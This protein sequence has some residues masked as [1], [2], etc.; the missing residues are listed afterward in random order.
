[1]TRKITFLLASVL[2]L[3]SAKPGLAGPPGREGPATTKKATTTRYIRLLQDD[4]KEPL[5]LQTATVRFTSAAGAGGVTV[6]LVGV[7]HIGDR[8]YYRK[9]N[10]QLEQYDVVLFELVA[11]PNT[12]I[13]RGG[14]RD[15]N[16]PLA[17]VQTAMKAVLGLESQTERID[18]TRKN[19]V[20]ADLSFEQ[21]AEAI[22]KRGDTGLTLTL[23]IAADLLRQQNLEDM[24][25]RDAQRGAQAEPEIDLLG[26]LLDPD[27][28]V[29][30]KRILAEQLAGAASGDSGLGP[31]INTILISDR[32]AAAIG[33]LQKELAKG[34][35][36]I[37][38]FYGAAHMP[39]FERRLRDDFGL[40]PQTPHWLDAWDL[41]FR[42]RG[43]LEEL[44]KQLLP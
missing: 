7:V 44:L 34:T 4:D 31:T 17:F 1:V 8:E 12:V 9:L 18:Y 20:H 13:P 29:K 42:P 30:L 36:K 10:K 2:F 14:K 37:A 21:M 11:P 15:P 23:S 35:K 25:K 27:G 6:D 5:A 28:G 40:R 38:I 39:D 41:R 22:R 19:F 16:N 33:V 43:G 24:K 32:N 26:M 3:G